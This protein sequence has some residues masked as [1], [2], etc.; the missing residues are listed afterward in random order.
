MDK[1]KYM[2]GDSALGVDLGTAIGLVVSG[3]GGA[4]TESLANRLA[5]KMP[6]DV[7]NELLGTRRDDV[8]REATPPEPSDD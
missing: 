8:I 6:L 2:V 5:G 3:R 1:K 4:I 7:L